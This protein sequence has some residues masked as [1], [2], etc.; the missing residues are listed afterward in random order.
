MMTKLGR[1]TG[2]ATT[3]QREILQEQVTYHKNRYH[4]SPVVDNIGEATSEFV[5]NEDMPTLDENDAATC[6][7]HQL[8]TQHLFSNDLIWYKG[9]VLFIPKLQSKGIQIIN[10]VIHPDEK[11]LFFL[12]E[13]RALLGQDS[14]DAIFEHSALVNAILKQYFE[15]LRG[16]NNDVYMRPPCEAMLYNVKPKQVKKRY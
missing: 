9:K 10:N 13:I 15:W 16:E 1:T 11:R 12:V 5:L 2:E 4:Q 14:A 3:N 8:R 6:I 7:S